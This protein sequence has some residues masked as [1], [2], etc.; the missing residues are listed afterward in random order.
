[1]PHFH[2]VGVRRWTNALVLGGLLLAGE[3]TMTAAAQDA[4][5]PARKRMLDEI[6]QQTRETRLEKIGRAHV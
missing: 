6:V 4:F 3:T 5:D 2:S 1:M